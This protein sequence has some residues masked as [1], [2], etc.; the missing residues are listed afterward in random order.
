M[1]KPGNL[2]FIKMTK[3]LFGTTIIYSILVAISHSDGIRNLL[4]H[5]LFDKIA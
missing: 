5:I 3:R 4:S 2:H 1:S